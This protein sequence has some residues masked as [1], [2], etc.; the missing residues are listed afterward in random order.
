MYETIL[1]PT[2]GS[3]CA[4]R[5]ARHGLAL[6]GRFDAAVHVLGVADVDRAAGPFNA[7]G[8]SDEFVDRV[9][10]EFESAV[11]SVADLAPS[12]APVRTAVVRGT[13]G[14]A[15][16]EYVRS[17]GVDLV[18]MGTQGRRGLRRFVTGSTTEHVVRHAHVPVVTVRQTEGPPVT[19]YDR[20]LV[21][22]DGSDHALAAVDHA[23][24]VADAS[25]AALHALYVVNIETL[26]SGP[27]A[28]PPT[29]LLET[30]QEQGREA[31]A[32]VADRAEA[33]GV[34]AVTEVREGFPGSMILEYA[35]AE[36]VDLIA[37]GTHGRTGV[38]RLLLGSTTERTIR[39][40]EVPVMSVHP[41]G[42]TGE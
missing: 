9:E 10:A 18:A 30:L 41:E 12:D 8:V 20:V 4:E 5:A 21:T 29:D 39:R 22:T 16:V 32:E 24:A 15:I 23:V 42:D 17:E 37:M 38:D 11:E 1:V 13:P 19:D 36:G 7:G 26:A 14:D 28:A 40:A 35:G 25:D 34:P 33:A 31:T 27:T 2:D 6:A 3:E